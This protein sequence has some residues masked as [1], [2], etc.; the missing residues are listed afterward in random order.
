[1]SVSLVLVLMGL[2]ALMTCAA[3]KAT[4]NVRRNMGFTVKMEQ[5]TGQADVNAMKTILSRARYVDSFVYTG[6]EEILAQESE[7]I[8]EDIMEL[9]DE[10]PYGAEFDVR[11]RADWADADS[12]R[13]ISTVLARQKGVEDVLS[14]TGIIDSVN[15]N[16]RHLSLIMLAVAGALLII[17][18]VLINNTVSLAVYSR[19][20]VIHTMR[21]VGATAAFIRRP[22]LSAGAVTGLI[23]AAVASAILAGIQAYATQADPMLASAF[24]WAD[25][26]AVYA[27]LAVAGVLICLLASAIATNRY[28][29]HDI[30][31]YYMN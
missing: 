25:S 9:V 7:I 18:F 21:L 19:R 6:P 13:A 22:F 27:L 12:I 14:D 15:R 4:D 16:L 23:A 10:N 29:R 30:D 2:T 28:L 26:A 17:S 8:G 20:F 3:R 1:M 5:G 31:D 24:S 11:L